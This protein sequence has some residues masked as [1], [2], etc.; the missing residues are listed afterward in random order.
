MTV[1]YLNWK[2]PWRH[3]SGLHRKE[4]ADELREDRLCAAY[5]FSAHV[6]IPSVRRVLSWR[7]PGQDFLL[8]GP[9]SL[10]GLCPTH[11]PGKPSGHRSPSSCSRTKALPQGNT[12]EGIPKYVR[13]RQP[14]QG[15]LTRTSHKYSSQGHGKPYVNDSFGIDS[16]HPVY[17]LDS[18]TI[19]LCLSL[20]PWAEFRKR[21]G[22][23]KLHTLSGSPGEHSHE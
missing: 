14:G 15:V 11:L 5:G 3:T 6:R 22:A 18:T 9:V 12:R 21:K 17:A 10:N 16:G 13:T 2:I 19:D 1:F 7:L 20:F 23:V 4:M 8:P